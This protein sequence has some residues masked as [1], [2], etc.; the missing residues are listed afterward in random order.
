MRIG[1]VGK[2]NVGKSTAFSALTEMPVDIANY[3]FT[4]IEPNVGV[5]WI[6]LPSPCACSDL[7]ERRESSG[8]LDTY[9]PD[10]DRGGQHLLAQHRLMFRIQEIGSSD[11][12]DVAGLVPGA[13]EGRGRGNQ[14][15]SDLS[16]CDALIQVVDVS[17]TTDLE[18]NPVGSGGSEPIEEH[19]FLLSELDSWIMG[20]IG[21]G[22]ERVSRR[23]QAEGKRAVQEHLMDRLTGIG[24]KDVHI[25][26]GIS[27]VQREYPDS[28]DI[29]SWGDDQLRAIASSIRKSMF[30]ISIAA[31][32]ADNQIHSC[33]ELE[34][35][36]ESSGG[37][38]I[39]TSAE[40]ELA[41]RRASSSGMIIYQPGDSDFSL[42]EA[43]EECS[44]KGREKH[45]GQS[46]ILFLLGEVA[47]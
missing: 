15:L 25:S 19:R 9:G 33:T 8:R 5:T 29:S 43:G 35:E 41:L 7:R 26:V 30:P 22:W 47:V 21:N 28:Q 1:L 4:T 16:R 32:K 10:D 24:A 17:G 23:A 3:P 20:I 34:S 12:V 38:V 39:F 11:P 14:F 37:R 44:Q 36:I 13:H 46:P 18:G 45:W 42:T 27:S 6:P 31:N 2:P 40:A